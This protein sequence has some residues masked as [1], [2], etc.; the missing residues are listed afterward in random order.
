MTVN[1]MG[2]VPRLQ[3]PGGNCVFALVS[4]LILRD[5][6]RSFNRLRLT[7]KGGPKESDGS[8]SGIAVTGLQML[9]AS[10]IFPGQS[11]FPILRASGIGIAL[12]ASAA[13]MPLHAQDDDPATL[14]PSAGQDKGIDIRVDWTQ[15]V[16][17]VIEGDAGGEPN[18]GGRIDGYV[19]VPGSTIGLDD[20]ITIDIH[21]EFR[22]GESANGEIGLL[23]TNTGLFY[24]QDGGEVFDLSASITKAWKNGA[25]LSVGKFNLLDFAAKF[26]IV[27]GGGNEG[28]Q[29]LA[30][31]L[32]PTGL[33][34]GSIVGAQFKTP[35]RIGLLRI[36]VF[37]PII[38]SRRDGFEDPFG[39]GVSVLVANTVPLKI[40]GE[41]GYYTVKLVG[42]TMRGA[43][44]SVYPQVLIPP[45]AAGFQD[46]KGGWNAAL[47][48]Q[49]YLNSYEGMPGKGIGWFGQLSFSDGFPTPL[50]WH[51]FTGIAGNP[52]SRPQDKFGV[53]YFRYSISDRLVD[54]L[55]TRLTLKDEQGVEA[56][57]TFQAANPLR[58]TANVQ[59]I[60]SAA[61]FRST[62]VVAGL[63]VKTSF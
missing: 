49:Q 41:Q 18:Y 14:P 57:Y 25:E 43:D 16:D 50:D 20:S 45:P 1:E 30:M 56:F 47:S 12:A 24:P 2:T 29:N 46:E 58:V 54:T 8:I 32:P 31:A 39:S 4:A 3:R 59:V 7:R 55:A 36:W 61:D 23:P 22:Y 63:R 26:P 37:D 52:K 44:F 48:W 42:T 34:P 60:D 62:G 9:S 10:L 51:L 33:V 5:I 27:G 11:F 6:S 38:A 19:A 40:G 21:P 13:A 15:F 35:T 53:A 28:F 17:A